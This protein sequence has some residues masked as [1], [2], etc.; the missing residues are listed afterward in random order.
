[1][2]NKWVKFVAAAVLY[3]CFAAY[4][5]FPHIRGLKISEY[6]L[7]LGAPAAAL[8]CYVLSRRWIASF[9][10]SFFAGVIYGFG[11]FVLWLGRFHPTAILLAAFIPWLFCPAVFGPDGKWRWVRIPLAALPFVAIVVF[12]QAAAYFRLFPVPLQTQLQARDILSMLAPLVA[13]R[14]GLIELGFYHVA[15]APLVIGFSMVFNA[16]RLG[17]IAAFGA[18]L[19]FALC[20]PILRVGPVTWLTIPMVCCSVI[21]GA[22]IQG[23][24]SSGFRDRVWVLSAATLCAALAI[25][26][27]LFASKCFQ[28]FAGLADGYGRLLVKTAWLYVLAAGTCAIIFLL[29]RTKLRAHWLRQL[30][31]FAALAFDIILGARQ[32]VDAVL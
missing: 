1:M 32:I 22:G 9:G 14:R 11:P 18:G 8:G 6:L 27:L 17:V 26:S 21:I 30:I 12:F 3:G 19:I 23:L 31:L 16:R 10:A 20:P 4:L 25:T 29:D 2:K 13:A 28:V 5:Y 7:I 15:I 24:V